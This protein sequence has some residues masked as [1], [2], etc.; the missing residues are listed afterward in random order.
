MIADEG[1]SSRVYGLVAKLPAKT[2]SLETCCASLETP[3]MD[4]AHIP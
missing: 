2:K 3:V 4:V 1:G